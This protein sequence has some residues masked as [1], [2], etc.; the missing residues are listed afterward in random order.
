MLT[1]LRIRDQS[2]EHRILDRVT[3]LLLRGYTF[4]SNAERLK[5]TYGDARFRLTRSSGKESGHLR[6]LSK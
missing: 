6:T 4:M 1:R 3:R 2:R 5:L